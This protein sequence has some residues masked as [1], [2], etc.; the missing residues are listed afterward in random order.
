MN[1]I[2]FETAKILWENLNTIES[3]LLGYKT[4]PDF[5]QLIEKVEINNSKH[6]PIK[7]EGKE[8]K[9][10]LNNLDNKKLSLH[11]K[12]QACKR[13][14]LHLSRKQAIEGRGIK[15]PLVLVILEAPTEEDDN[16]GTL[17]TGEAGVLLE[18]M[19][20]SISLFDTK[21]CYITPI[22]KCKPP[23]NKLPLLDQMYACKS[24]LDIQIQRMKPSFILALG[25]VTSLCL[26]GPKRNFRDIRGK[27]LDY[28]LSSMQESS[29][30]ILISFSPQSLLH[31]ETLKR[32]A[33]QD[34]KLVR[35]VLDD[36][37]NSEGKKK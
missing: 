5:N 8:S 35:K 17:L 3:S 32:P 34:L 13:C 11:E 9:E 25:S 27:V 31:D 15:T 6:L 7:Q 36:L 30:P 37:E 23:E 22:V 28:K 16:A 1:K 2:S 29:I 24:F 26:F 19:L 10:S 12:I 21:N 14:S 18:K 4:K 33:W 20:S